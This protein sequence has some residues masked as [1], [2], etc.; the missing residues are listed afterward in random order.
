M[1]KNHIF[2]RFLKETRCYGWNL[3]SEL[4]E[5]DNNL[6]GYNIKVSLEQNSGRQIDD[7]EGR[8]VNYFFRGRVRRDWRPDL[9]HFKNFDF[10]PFHVP[11]TAQDY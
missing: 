10:C 5:S 8:L 2:H 4:I 1:Q 6:L 7:K 3:L 11:E 9:I